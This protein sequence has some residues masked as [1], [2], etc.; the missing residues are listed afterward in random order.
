MYII[1][2]TY[3]NYNQPKSSII[4]QHLNAIQIF[5]IRMKWNVF[6]WRVGRYIL[7]LS[8]VH[9]IVYLQDRY[10]KNVWTKTGSFLQMTIYHIYLLSYY[11]RFS[12][13]Y[14][15][16]AAP[17]FTELLQKNLWCIIRH[18]KMNCK[19]LCVFFKKKKIILWYVA[20]QGIW[21]VFCI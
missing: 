4:I 2:F 13:G 17:I 19:Y 1:T 8:E 10:A 9:Y 16:F 20:I 11:A 12:L 6:L 21:I 15:L 18:L 14:S 3:F 7:S 5:N